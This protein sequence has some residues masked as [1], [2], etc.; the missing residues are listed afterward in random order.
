MQVLSARRRH[1]KLSALGSSRFQRTFHP[2]RILSL[3]FPNYSVFCEL[4]SLKKSINKYITKIQKKIS[5]CD[6]LVKMK[7]VSPR[8][9]A[10]SLSYLNVAWS[11][12]CLVRVIIT[13]HIFSDNFSRVDFYI[14]LIAP[15]NKLFFIMN[16][17]KNSITL[18][19]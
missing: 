16:T 15:T 14:M 12:W 10:V 8:S 13:L 6:Y 9:D 5:I 3:L 19:L 4:R 2:S 18:I 7:C 1:E 11:S 17:L